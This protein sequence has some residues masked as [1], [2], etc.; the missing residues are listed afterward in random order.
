M[1]SNV[2]V[3]AALG[4]LLVVASRA[5]SE[6]QPARG[7][8]AYVDQQRV[9]EESEPGK[10]ALADLRAKLEANHVALSKERDAIQIENEAVQKG[11]FEPGDA[12]RRRADLQK[13]TVAWQERYQKVQAQMREDETRTTAGIMDQIKKA[14][15]LLGVERRCECILNSSVVL[16]QNQNFGP[17]LGTPSLTP[18]GRFFKLG[19]L[20]KF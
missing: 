1:R 7:S 16:N 14:C 2:L 19:G 20:I 11:Q 3:A 6:D 5:V 15:A 12:A 17:T 10:R 18:F 9:L 4:A 8:V 13:R